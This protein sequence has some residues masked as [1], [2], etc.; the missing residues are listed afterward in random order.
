MKTIVRGAR[1]MTCDPS[2]GGLGLIDDGATV[3]RAVLNAVSRLG[4]R[5][6]EC[7]EGP[8]PGRRS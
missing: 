8:V 2:R 4:V 6:P 1:L 7:G 5:P 3:A